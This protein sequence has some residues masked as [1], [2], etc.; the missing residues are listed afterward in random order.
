LDEDEFAEHAVLYGYPPEYYSRVQKA[1]KE[2]L[3]LMEKRSFPFSLN[4]TVENSNA[5]HT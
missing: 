1:V 5:G 2:I 4:V 3:S